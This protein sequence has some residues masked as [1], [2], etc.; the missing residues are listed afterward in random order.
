MRYTVAPN[1]LGANLS[2]VSCGAVK[3]AIFD[4]HDDFYRQEN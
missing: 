3:I 1:A 2:D 4:R